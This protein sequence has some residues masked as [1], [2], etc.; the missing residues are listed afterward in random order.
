MADERKTAFEIRQRD[1]R[2]FVRRKRDRFEVIDKDAIGRP[3]PQHMMRQAS[4][5]GTE[6]QETPEQ[7]NVRRQT[8]LCALTAMATLAVAAAFITWKV[9]ERARPVSGVESNGVQTALLQ[10]TTPAEESFSLN[11]GNVTVD[12]SGRTFFHVTLTN[13]SDQTRDVTMTLSAT[14]EGTDEKGGNWT[15]E[16]SSIRADAPAQN[17]AWHED[18]IHVIDVDAHTS[19]GFDLY[20]SLENVDVGKA[21]PTRISKVDLKLDQSAPS[22]PQRRRVAAKDLT[23]RQYISEDG[24]NVM[25]SGEFLNDTGQPLDKARI[26]VWFIDT[27]LNVSGATEPLGKNAP[28][29]L[30][31]GYVELGHVMNGQLV[32]FEGKFEIGDTK[33]AQAHAIA[34]VA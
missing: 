20:P 29:G 2:R 9:T 14:L 12:K 18:R 25:V 15:S 28:K 4:L 22:D 33:A 19:R 6:T 32:P 10:D 24:K 21:K 34:L 3:E 8:V 23:Y 17:V 30:R 13:D 5:I 27:S 16:V 31:I 7:P 26:A 11:T 1:G